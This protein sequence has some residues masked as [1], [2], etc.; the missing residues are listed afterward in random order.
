[1]TFYAAV[2]LSNSSPSCHIGWLESCCDHNI[3]A[4]VFHSPTFFIFPKAFS[5]IW[6]H[7]H[8]TSALDFES[9]PS[10]LQCVVENSPN[11][12]QAHL[13]GFMAFISSGSERKPFLLTLCSIKNKEACCN[14]V[15]S[16]FNCIPCSGHLCNSFLSFL[17][18]SA[19]AF[20]M[21]LT[22]P[23]TRSSALLTTPSKSV[24]SLYRT[25]WNISWA[26]A[27]PN[28]RTYPRNRPN[29]VG[30]RSQTTDYLVQFQMT[31]SI[32]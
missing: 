27:I 2:Q 13:N 8:G 9:L 4:Q 28:G 22:F 12:S 16:V 32:S 24:I 14:S 10:R 3:F 30:E 26:G 11:S 6:D 18:W 5:W 17:S 1:M 19:V 31:K 29:G 15:F 25:F 23:T 7:V 21:V 20:S